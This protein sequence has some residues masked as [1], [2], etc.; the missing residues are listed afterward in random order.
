MDTLLE[1]LYAISTALLV[2][3]IVVLLGFVTW[4]LLEIGGFL[5]EWQDRRRAA[6]TWQAFLAR[7]GS[8]PTPAA[9]AACSFFE[10]S[11]YPGLVGS[12]ARRG[13]SHFREAAF[14]NKLV[15]D[16]EIEAAGRLA[17]MNLGIRLGPMLGLMGTLIPLGP[18]LLALSQDNIDLMGRSLVVAFCTTV[19]GLL[20][21]GLC[22][23]MLLA[24]RQWYAQDI[25][26]V[27]FIDQLL[28][29]FVD[30][31]LN[32]TDSRI[33]Q[34]SDHAPRDGSEPPAST[35]PATAANRR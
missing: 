29:E 13:R 16:L 6:A 22:Y 2:P 20:V 18:A 10:A 8:S 19:L 26:N 28:V 4:C 1:I 24:R 23:A 32:D 17:A 7:L 33:A 9:D 15:S 25:A 35:Q 34:E 30:Q 14:R 5:R 12:F 21:G 3:V 27:E 31:L 11:D